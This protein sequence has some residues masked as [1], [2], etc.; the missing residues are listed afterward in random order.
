MLLDDASGPECDSA[1]SNLSPED[2]LF[3]GLMKS[4]FTHEWDRDLKR[5][6]RSYRVSECLSTSHG[7][8]WFIKRNYGLV[9]H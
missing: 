2:V 9:S 7:F 6:L 3:D 4:D 8:L 1:A 5:R